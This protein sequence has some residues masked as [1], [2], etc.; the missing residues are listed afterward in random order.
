MSPREKFCMRWRSINQPDTFIEHLLGAKFCAEQ[1]TEFL[2]KFIIW[3]KDRV[4][5]AKDT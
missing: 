1:Q 4:Y 2:K 5:V 3:L